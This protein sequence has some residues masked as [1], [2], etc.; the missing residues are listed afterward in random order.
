MEMIDNKKIG[1]LKDHIKSFSN[2][3]HPES[4][5]I[6]ILHKA[7]ELFGYLD[8]D[9]MNEIALFMNIPRAHIWGVATFYHFFRLKPQGKH[10]I[11]ICLGTACYVKGASEIL[12]M[13][14][15]EL[16]IDIGETTQDGLFTLIETRCLGACGL[17][18]V[19]MIDE[20]IYG[21]ITP[22]KAIEILKT[23]K[24]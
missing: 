23:F 9:V 16:K 19:I 13:I 7:Q 18:P 5:L 21:N 8:K 10:S 2:K 17:A 6:A 22:K 3:P 15:S 24:K 4:N 11:S 14:K 20:K 12:D 1:I